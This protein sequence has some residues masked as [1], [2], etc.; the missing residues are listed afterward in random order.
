MIVVKSNLFHANDFLPMEI[1]IN[2][3]RIF[4]NSYLIFLCH[5]ILI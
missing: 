4:Y 5:I 1:F 3:I 2:N